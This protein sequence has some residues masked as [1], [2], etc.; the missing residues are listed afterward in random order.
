MAR[1]PILVDLVLFCFSAVVVDPKIF[2]SDLQQTQLSQHQSAQITTNHHQSPPISVGHHSG[3][4]AVICVLSSSP[5][6][7]TD[8]SAQ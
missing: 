4:L 5:W 6:R 7:T 2:A 3:V 1:K 8:A